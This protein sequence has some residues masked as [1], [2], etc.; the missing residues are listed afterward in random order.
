MKA[1]ILQYVRTCHMCIRTRVDRRLPQG[2]LKTL[3]VP[4]LPFEIVSTDEMSGFPSVDNK[5]S[6]MVVRDRATKY[7]VFIP[8]NKTLKAEEMA[9]LFFNEVSI[10]YGIPRQIISDRG[11]K[12]TSDFWTELTRLFGIQRGL[13]TAYHPQTDGQTERVNLDIQAY[14]R[15]F[16][17]E[18]QDDWP[19]HLK[20]AQYVFNN[21]LHTSIGMSPNMALMGYN[22]PFPKE[23]EYA[24]PQ[25]RNPGARL[26]AKSLLQVR[27]IAR[28][29]HQ[30]ALADMK[31]F[32][33]RH[34]RDAPIF[35]VGDKVFLSLEHLSTKRPSKKIDYQWDGPFEINE[36][37]N[38][39]AYRVKL[40]TGTGKPPHDVFHISR[41]RKMDEEEDTAQDLPNAKRFV[42]SL[43]QEKPFLTTIH[44]EDQEYEVSKILDSRRRGR[45]LE[46]LV[47][48]KGY[49]EDE[50]QWEPEKHLD[51]ALD[52]VLDFHS[53]HADRPKG[54]TH[55]KALRRVARQ[56]SRTMIL[57]KGV[58]S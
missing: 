50:R 39:H 55:Q 11:S 40:P 5:D 57:T 43:E 31:R 34:R 54:K 41:L 6:I 13:S 1:D 23:L 2:L 29:C 9:E 32:A 56:S 20:M 58:M 15:A 21:A 49:G 18:K 38:T 4:H 14:L 27:D 7:S 35:S 28:L 51:N 26:R 44:P 17:N 25:V 22:I 53:E 48:W 42:R 10:K 12:Y 16:V 52:A 33:D 3:P 19:R 45:S 36:I 30:R 8:V 46:Y 47:D 37:I 24:D